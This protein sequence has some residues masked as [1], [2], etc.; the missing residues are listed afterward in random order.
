MKLLKVVFL[1]FVLLTLSLSAHAERSFGDIYKE[2]GLG[3]LIFP[4]D[5]IIAVV[6]NVTW[7]LGTTAVTS[8]MSSPDTCHG[9][10]A[11]MAAFILDAHPQ[12]EQ[13][14]STGEGE[15]LSAM[16]SLMGCES[17]VDTSVALRASFADAIEQ[18]YFE[19]SD[20]E[21]ST[22]LFNAASTA[23]AQHCTI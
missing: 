17:S 2:C 9:G 6:T 19:A 11:S 15:Y 23:A 4:E 8:D 10:K 22:M 1:P 3:A 21:K 5:P 13:D 20:F 7:D 12:I 16:V 14:L 18:G